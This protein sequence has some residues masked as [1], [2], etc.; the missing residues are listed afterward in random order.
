MLIQS[1]ALSRIHIAS[2][3]RLLFLL[4]V[5]CLLKLVFRVKH[6]TIVYSFSCTEWVVVDIHLLPSTSSSTLVY[7][8]CL[9]APTIGVLMN[10]TLHFITCFKFSLLTRG[11]ISSTEVTDIWVNR[12][13]RSLSV[14]TCICF[15]SHFACFRRRDNLLDT[16]LLYNFILLWLFSICRFASIV[17]TIDGGYFVIRQTVI[18]SLL[19]FLRIWSIVDVFINEAKVHLVFRLS[20]F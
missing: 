10:Y 7:L 9:S 4:V 1:L 2:E 20:I 16:I 19:L 17:F 11:F 8:N 15:I 3:C 5:F 18:R 6:T 13:I 12:I 14:S